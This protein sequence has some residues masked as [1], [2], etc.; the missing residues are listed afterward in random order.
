KTE[1]GT[2][3][4][5]PGRDHA[6]K[7]LP[8]FRLARFPQAKL[9]EVTVPFGLELNRSDVTDAGLKNL[10]GLG[11]LSML[12]LRGARGVTDAGLKELSGLKNLAA[13][14]LRGTRLTDAGVAWLRKALPAC[15]IRH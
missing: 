13:L 9:P 12:G 14:H 8:G 3:W 11:K 15:E 1:A 4:F 7:G 2:I 6:E 10:A 5:Q